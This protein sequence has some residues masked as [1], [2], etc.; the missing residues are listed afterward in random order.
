MIKKDALFL[1]CL[2]AMFFFLTACE[3]DRDP[4]LQPTSVPMRVIAKR[5]LTD[6]MFVDSLLPDPVWLRIDT[7]LGLVYP[8]NT[9]SFS[10]LLSPLTDSCSYALMP[11]SSAVNSIDTLTFYYNR[12][13]HFLSNACG[14]TYFF[15]L[16]RISTTTNNID[17]V[18]IINSDVNL[19]ASAPEH[20]QIFF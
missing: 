12:N 17:S 6:S 2:G 1:A 10:L 20:V 7:A 11:D 4:C 3:Q 9:S 13:L 15:S 14:F 16:Q 5:P 19:N 18:R 8:S